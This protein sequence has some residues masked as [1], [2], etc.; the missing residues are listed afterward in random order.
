MKIPGI[1]LFLALLCSCY[2]DRELGFLKTRCNEALKCRIPFSVAISRAEELDGQRIQIIGVVR[3]TQGGKLMF[4]SEFVHPIISEVESIKLN[5]T[6]L[7]ETPLQHETHNGMRMLI[8]GIL[9][10]QSDPKKYAWAEMDVISFREFDGP[11]NVKNL[12]YGN[13]PEAD[14]Q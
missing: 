5:F 11:L 8:D 6:K 14:S 2:S 7:G 12:W 10:F 9:H 4:E 3:S 1:L 13:P